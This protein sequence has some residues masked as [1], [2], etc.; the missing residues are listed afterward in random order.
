M[1]RAALLRSMSFLGHDTGDHVEIPGRI[2]AIER[3]L[4]RLNMI[5]GRPDVSF[6]LLAVDEIATTHDPR[7]LD[8][9]ERYAAMG[10]GW[11]D[12]DTFC[13]SDSLAVARLA[14][15]A[16]VAAVE[17]AM[18]GSIKRAF[19]LGRP[20]GHHA[21]ATHGMGFCLLNSI[22]IA[23]N[24]A[25][26]NGAERVAIVDWDVHHGNGTQDIFYESNRV[27]F[28]STH[29]YGEFYPGTGA[30]SERGR[31]AGLGFTV[32]VPLR[33]GDGDRTVINVFRDAV[34]PAVAAFEPELV[35]VSAGFDAHCADPLGGLAMTEQ[36]FYELTAMT[37]E[38]ADRRAGGR[39]VAL[40]E[41]GYD[42]GALGRSV[43]ATIEALDGK[44]FGVYDASE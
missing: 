40:L 36:G 42:P 16:A 15:G 35:L 18:N 37:A 19:V 34:L 43:V 30:A 10:G 17:A 32:N 31:G 21:T 9:L 33:E 11:I 24:H 3:E 25:L 7:Y 6:Q 12:A 20:P 14:A 26:A 38:V 29:R 8:A 1:T 2:R 41:G 23:A 13:G 28:C 39:L 5:S 22:A 44:P 27:L 4:H